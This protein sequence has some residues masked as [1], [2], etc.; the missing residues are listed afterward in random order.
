MLPQTSQD[1]SVR[2]IWREQ[3]KASFII[4]SLKI[5]ASNKLM[6]EHQKHL[7]FFLTKMYGEYE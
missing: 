7:E 5:I 3:W 1:V 4:K 2:I 6:F